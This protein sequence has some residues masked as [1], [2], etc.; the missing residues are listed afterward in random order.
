MVYNAKYNFLFVHIQKTAGT[1][2]T[3]ALLEIPSSQFIAPAHLRLKDIT[4][5]K[6]KPFIFAVIRNPWDRLISWHEMIIRKGIHND[7]SRYILS[8]ISLK[9]NHIN[10]SEFIRKI[11][12]IDE[13]SLSELGQSLIGSENEEFK[14]A[15]R[16]LKS[17]AFNQAD[18]LTDA[19]DLNNFNKVLRFENLEKDWADLVMQLKLP[20]RLS[21]TFE[22]INPTPV[23]YSK[24]Y[25]SSK[26][27][28]W[29]EELYY[30]D[31][32]LFGYTR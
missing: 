32:Q 31:I 21:L 3:K 29:V 9:P 24:Y 14:I 17:I 19:E 1:S 10:F 6:K 30:K 15:E 4:F 11:N 26:D 23:D 8:S 25:S 28:K 13:K 27:I 20:I 5:L 2:I 16:Y 22:N 7:F 12:V 18:Y